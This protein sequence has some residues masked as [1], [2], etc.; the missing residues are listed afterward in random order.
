MGRH[1]ESL[2]AA[3]SYLQ[4]DG[5]VSSV[6]LQIRRIPLVP[7]FKLYLL[8]G[9]EA[10]FG[11]YMVCERS[12]VMEDGEV[13]EGVLDVQGLGAGLTHHVKDA[14]LHSQGTVLV[15]NMQE[16][17]DSTWEHLAE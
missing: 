17:F 15:T 9:T 4:T 13:I 11:P 2:R 1:T 12:I 7:Q 3:L 5:L 10:L 16:W 6:D 14:E 8:N